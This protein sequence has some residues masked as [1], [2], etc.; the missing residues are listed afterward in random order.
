MLLRDLILEQFADQFGDSAGNR[1]IAS[2]MS[3]L[4][5]K[6]DEITGSL[7]LNWFLSLFHNAV[8]WQVSLLVYRSQKID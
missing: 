2:Q 6:V 5:N 1:P 7:T 4:K 8:P 3:Q